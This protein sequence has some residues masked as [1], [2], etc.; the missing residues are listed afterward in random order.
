[1][2]KIEVTVETLNAAVTKGRSNAVIA[3]LR[4]RN[5]KPVNSQKLND[6][7]KQLRYKDYAEATLESSLMGWIWVP[8]IFILFV[9]II[10]LNLKNI[11]LSIPL[12]VSPI[13]LPL[14]YRIYLTCYFKKYY[15]KIPDSFVENSIELPCSDTKF[16][17]NEIIQAADWC[18]NKVREYPYNYWDL[19]CN[20]RDITLAYV[21][22]QRD[23]NTNNFP[24]ILQLKVTDFLAELA[25]ILNNKSK[26]NAIKNNDTQFLVWIQRIVELYDR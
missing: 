9:I 1:M 6:I 12:L 21:L 17:E 13:L 2:D 15:K 19:I 26:Y 24:I 25:D 4:S 16:Y 10:V 3:E 20:N 22:Y 14:C 8:L 7:H 5:G 23:K 11:F 18:S